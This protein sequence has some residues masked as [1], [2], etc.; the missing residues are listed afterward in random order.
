MRRTPRDG[1][2]RLQLSLGEIGFW[3]PGNRC[4]TAAHRA[5]RRRR[6]RHVRDPSARVGHSARTREEHARYREQ[7]SLGFPLERAPDESLVLEIRSALWSSGLV[8]AAGSL[9]IL[10]A[11]YGSRLHVHRR[12]RRA[13]ARVHRAIVLTVS[14]GGTVVLANLRSAAGSR[15]IVLSDE[16]TTTDR[17]MGSRPNSSVHRGGRASRHRMW[18]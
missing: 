9:D 17:R 15:E 10:I 12:C 8:R 14:R 13:P 5:C 16:R 4:A 11:G 1:L 7:I 3:R 18:R 2:P 6:V